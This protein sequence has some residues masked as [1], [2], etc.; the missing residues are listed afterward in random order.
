MADGCIGDTGHGQLKVIL[1]LKLSDLAH[2]EAFKRFLNSGHKIT[3]SKKDRTFNAK[4]Q[5]ASTRIARK[6]SDYGIG[7]RKSFT[8]EAAPCVALSRHFWRG[9]IDGDGYMKLRVHRKSLIP[10]FELVGSESLLAQFLSF[11]RAYGLVTSATPR[12]NK[13]KKIWH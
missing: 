2:V 8:A 7:P 6:L 12:L 4:L 1:E 10:K 13:K 5:I 9:V 11:A 3:I